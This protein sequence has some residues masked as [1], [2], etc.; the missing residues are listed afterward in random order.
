[1]LRQAQHERKNFNDFNMVLSLSQ[2]AERVFQQPVN[3]VTVNLSSCVAEALKRT[4]RWTEASKYP[5][6]RLDSI[7]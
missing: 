7:I 4:A 1:M 3:S 6:A 2:D 5:A